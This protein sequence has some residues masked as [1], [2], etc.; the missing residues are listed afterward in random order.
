MPLGQQL[1]TSHGCTQCHQAELPVMRQALG[2]VAPD[3]AWFSRLVYDHTGSMPELEKML[4]DNAP[5]RM[6]NF[7]NL[8]LPEPV[9]QEIWKYISGD[10]GFRARVQARLT[11]GAPASGGT[12][13]TVTVT[14]TG[15]VGKGPAVEDVTVALTL[16]AG[17]TV[18]GTTGAGYQGTTKDQ[19]G[20]DV[21][22]WR[23]P[24]IAAKE[25]SAFTIT[26]SGNAPVKSGTVRWV[27]PGVKNG[28]A[29]DQINVAMP[30][31]PA[32]TQ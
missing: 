4:G 17:A 26:L 2:A 22:R 16:P 20:L 25:A 13:Y 28:V 3:F 10:L 12:A 7:S 31:R 29:G 8:R 15:L 11:T 32:A 21:A 18:V 24:R 27:K 23:V 6:G 30:P 19:K 5:I 1:A 14:N 9:L